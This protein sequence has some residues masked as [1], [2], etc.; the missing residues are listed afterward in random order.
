MKPEFSKKSFFSVSLGTLIEYYDYALLA[1]FLPIIAPVFFP[2][3]TAYA[4]LTKGYWVLLIAMLARPLGGLL[5][6]YIGDWLGRRRALLYSI[7]GIA[8]ATLIVGL[9]PGYAVIGLW[10]MVI[11]TVTKSIQLFCFGGEYNGAGIYVV[12]HAQG[13]REGFYGSLLTAM[14]LVGALLA[15][16]I[17]VVLTQS[18]MPTWS[19]R[20]AYFIGALIGFWGLLYRKQ[21]PESPQFKAA[22]LRIHTLK[23][24]IQTYPWQLLAG[25]FI[26][27]FAT[28]PFTTV[29]TFINPVL[30]T[31]GYFTSHQMMWLQTGLVVVAILTLITAGHIADR[32][33][34]KRVMQIGAILLVF[35]AYPLLLLVNTKLIGFLVLAQT[36]LIILNEILL[37]PS[38][39]YLKKAF[40]IEYRYRASS[41]SF[42]AG[43]SLI[44]GLTPVIENALYHYT[45]SFAS[46]SLWIILVSVFTVLSIQLSSQPGKNVQ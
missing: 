1:I 34:A 16:I 42:C 26:G 29:L 44:G 8:V 6:G 28:L 13:Y 27:G 33:S 18:S 23:Q 17:G 45:G 25:F 4:A 15:T 21:L 11:I 32:Y 37:G 40:P 2:G 43:M 41:F 35:L 14:T 38:N 39:A 10:A 46:A 24:L 5:F 9:L 12:E 7:A 19:W 30:M 31:T 36:I 20:I 22:D 3:K